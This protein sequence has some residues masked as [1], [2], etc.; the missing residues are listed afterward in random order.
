MADTATPITTPA[1]QIP[2]LV[3][4]TFDVKAMLPTLLAPVF[5]TIESPNAIMMVAA[6][7]IA[8]LQGVDFKDLKAI[9]P[10]MEKIY[11]EISAVAPI[12]MQVLMAI[13]EITAAAIIIQSNIPGVATPITAVTAIPLILGALTTIINLLSSLGLLKKFG[14]LVNPI[15][16]FLV[17]VLLPPIFEPITAL[18]A[19]MTSITDTVGQVPI[20][21][22]LLVSILV[23]SP[24]QGI[25][26]GMPTIDS[27]KQQ[28]NSF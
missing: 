5:S 7:Q 1:F 22:T 3:P 9:A 15:T 12:V 14:E 23:P 8:I 4:P 10:K 21:G 18:K 6:L 26:D 11:N 20:A 13:A 16:D 27:I 17:N 24:L 19:L 28:L 25:I 2:S